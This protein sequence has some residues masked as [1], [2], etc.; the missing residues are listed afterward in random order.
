MGRC[1]FENMTRRLIRR[2]G[3][4]VFVVDETNAALPEKRGVFSHPE[5]DSTIKG[6]KGGISVTARRPELLMLTADCVGISKAWRITVNGQEYF[7]AEWLDDGYGGTRLHL[8]YAQAQQE[9]DPPPSGE[10]GSSASVW[11]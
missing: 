8:S 3:K 6:K 9:A 11:R 1:P 2:Q 7:A 4:P 10:E 5:I